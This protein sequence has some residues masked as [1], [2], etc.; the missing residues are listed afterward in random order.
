MVSK[1]RTEELPQITL[2]F[3]V[4]LFYDSSNKHN[5]SLLKNHLISR[6]TSTVERDYNSIV[7]G[8]ILTTVL[9]SEY[10][11]WGKD[12]KNNTVTFYC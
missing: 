12:V 5:E 9:S 7:I 2:W 10:V 4:R 11:L 8:R 1:K 6:A 3:T